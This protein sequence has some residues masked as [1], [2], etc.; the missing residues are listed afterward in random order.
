MVALAKTLWGQ[1]PFQG[2]LPASI[3]DMYRLG[4]GIET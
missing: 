2:H 4:H 3:P 1:I